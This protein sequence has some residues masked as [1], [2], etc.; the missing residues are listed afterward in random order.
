MNFGGDAS[1]NRRRNGGHLNVQVI[2]PGQAEIVGSKHFV[3]EL[4]AGVL[5]LLLLS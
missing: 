5:I 2:R 4:F 3:I 1:R